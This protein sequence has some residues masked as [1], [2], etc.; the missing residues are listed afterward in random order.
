MIPWRNC[1]LNV[2]RLPE[3]GGEIACQLWRD[4]LKTVE[5]KPENCGEF[6]CYRGEIACSVTHCYFSLYSN[7]WRNCLKNFHL[8]FSLDL[9]GKSSV[10]TLLNHHVHA[11]LECPGSVPSD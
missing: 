2:E 11:F 6:A 10:S 1:L 4:C 5:K 8:G 9:M 3:N 7:P